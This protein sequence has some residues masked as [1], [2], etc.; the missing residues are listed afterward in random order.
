MRASEPVRHE[1]SVMSSRLRSIDGSPPLGVFGSFEALSAL[2]VGNRVHF[3]GENVW[4]WEANFQGFPL[5]DLSN[6]AET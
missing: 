5:I 2:Q 3:M 4:K 6:G 1:Y